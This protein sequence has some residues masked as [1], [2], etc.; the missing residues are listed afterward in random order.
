MN[1][2]KGSRLL[3]SQWRSNVLALPS[4]RNYRESEN[5]TFDWDKVPET[6][7][8]EKEKFQEEN[9]INIIGFM[10]YHSKQDLEN[11]NYIFQSYYLFLLV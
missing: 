7:E 8:K 11:Q 5:F 10:A 6:L 1:I 3:L 4:I 2:Y 9:F